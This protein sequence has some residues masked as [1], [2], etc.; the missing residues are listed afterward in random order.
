MEP[1]FRCPIC[2]ESLPMAEMCFTKCGA[3]MERPAQSSCADTHSKSTPSAGGSVPEGS[4]TEGE[5]PD[6]TFRDGNQA[7]LELDS[8][9]TVS[10]SQT[11]ERMSLLAKA[12]HASRMRHKLRGSHGLSAGL[13]SSMPTV[14]AATPLVPE[15]AFSSDDYSLGVRSTPD[16]ADCPDGHALGRAPRHCF[17]NGCID[18]FDIEGR[19]CPLCRTFVRFVI[20]CPRFVETD[21][22]AYDDLKRRYDQLRG[23]RDALKAERDALRASY[24]RLRAQL[25]QLQREARRTSHYSMAYSSPSSPAP[26]S[27]Q[28]SGTPFQPGIPPR[29]LGAPHDARALREHRLRRPT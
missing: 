5:D 11:D 19:A 27:A 23:E 7:G 1:L 9:G 2:F 28:D 20:P 15:P 22:S 8:T 14:L 6:L 26:P 17:C 13:L 10:Q 25:G 12:Q 21:H 24:E 3:S 29:D 16:T 4:S 18:T